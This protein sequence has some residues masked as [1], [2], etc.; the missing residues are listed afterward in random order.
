[1]RLPCAGVPVEFLSDEQA[2]AYGR[3]TG[4]P[5]Q[6]EL[7]RYFFLDDADKAVIGRR[8][9]D[10]SRLGFALQVVTVRFIGTFLADPLDVPVEVLDYV[11]E[12]LTIADP[13][14]VKRYTEREKT[15]LEHAWEIQQAYG[16]KDFADAEPELTKWID[17]RAWTTGDGPKAIFDGAVGWLRD[18][19]VLLPGVTTLARLVARVR[20]EATQRLWERLYG[21]LSPEQRVMLDVLLE[22]PEGARVSEW[23]RLRKGPTKASGP[24]MIKALH[25]IA[26]VAG[27]GLG[28]L[29]LGVVPPRRVAELAKYGLAGRTPALKLNVFEGFQGC[30][31]VFS[32]IFNKR[33]FVE[34]RAPGDHAV[35]RA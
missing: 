23:D 2:A 4:P 28:S 9:G 27:L 32:V 11:A 26:E 29:D 8:R 3:F 6:V 34:A 17:A 22:V 7:E 1:M 18:R 21:L 24:G 15:R 12:Q 31:R 13:S 10:H 33:W 35:R 16:W 14:C 5:S 30:V 25:R 20:E 19:R